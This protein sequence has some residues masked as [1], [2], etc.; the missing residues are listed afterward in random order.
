MFCL[1]T[2]GT[3]QVASISMLCCGQP[4]FDRLCWALPVMQQLG[5]HPT[6]RGHHIRISFI[7]E[8]RLGSVPPDPGLVQNTETSLQGVWLLWTLARSVRGQT[9]SGRRLSGGSWQHL[10]LLPNNCPVRVQVG[11]R[12]HAE[13]SD[14]GPASS[15]RTH[16]LCQSTLE[17]CNTEPS[18]GTCPSSPR[19]SIPHPS[20]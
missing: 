19:L 10:Q 8:V 15:L 9:S 16:C 12:N 14:G 5:C 18:Q 11:E 2:N 6:G 13:T 20:R 17:R 4:H 1:Q 3:L 7:L